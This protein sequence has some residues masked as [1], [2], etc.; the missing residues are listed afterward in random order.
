MLH[1]G[2]CLLAF[3]ESLFFLLK[4][5]FLQLNGYL[6]GIVCLHLIQDPFPFFGKSFGDDFLI[7]NNSPNPATRNPLYRAEE[8]QRRVARRYKKRECEKVW[9]LRTGMVES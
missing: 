7:P 3:G 4:G 5:R 9:N 2:C 6:P 1:A 8:F